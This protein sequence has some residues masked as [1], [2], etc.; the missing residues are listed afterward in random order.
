MIDIYLK[1]KP[2]IKKNYLN[3][4]LVCQELC[5]LDKRFP[6]NGLWVEY[7]KV[8]ELN[9]I[10]KISSVAKKRGVIL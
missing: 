8:K 3:L 2:E 5:K 6:P 9:E 10:I 1:E 7:Y 4:S